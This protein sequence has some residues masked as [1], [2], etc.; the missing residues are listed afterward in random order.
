MPSSQLKA[1]G[2]EKHV[3]KESNTTVSAASTVHTHYTRTQLTLA[4][5]QYTGLEPPS[6]QAKETAVCT[7]TIH[8]VRGQLLAGT[9]RDGHGTALRVKAKGSELTQKGSELRQKS[10]ELRQ[11][12][13]ELRKKGTK[14]RQTPLTS[15]N[16]HEVT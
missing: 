3:A 11:R 12:S 2:A 16:R 9:G 1:Q 10:S 14:L 7:S 4:N 15:V 8:R 13:S 5:A 6:I